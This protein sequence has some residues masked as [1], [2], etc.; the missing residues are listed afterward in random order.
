MRGEI[1]ASPP[2]VIPKK[3]RPGQKIS[4]TAPSA[5]RNAARVSG[6]PGDNY[7]YSSSLVGP[8]MDES[9]VLLSTSASSQSSSTILR[10]QEATALG[11]GATAVSVNADRGGGEGGGGGI[12]KSYLTKSVSVDDEYVKIQ[13]RNE[14]KRMDHATT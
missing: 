6:D 4:S 2:V 1:S 11:Y 14:A 8:V 5:A 13:M 3:A 7:P 9:E 10:H 12:D